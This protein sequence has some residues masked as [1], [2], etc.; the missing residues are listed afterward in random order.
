M[1]VG[2]FVSLILIAFGLSA[3]CFAVALGGGISRQGLTWRAQLRVAALFGLFQAIMPALGW[4]AGKTI[5]DLIAAYDHWVA[6]ALLAGVGGRMLWESFRPGAGRGKEID[7]SRGLLLITLSVATSI[8]A[9]A[10]GLSFAL[11]DVNILAAS[12]TI[13]VV[14][15]LVTITGFVAGRKASRVVGKR[16]ETLGG[17]VLLAIAVRILLSHLFA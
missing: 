15:F 14:A 5:V 6:F 13:G 7:I 9:L 11:L 4:L 3:D 17:L 16:A 8:D 2:D 12:L 1:T 10:V